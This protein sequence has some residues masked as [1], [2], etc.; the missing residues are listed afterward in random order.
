MIGA[1]GGIRYEVGAGSGIVNCS[2][3]LEPLIGV[4][5]VQ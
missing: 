2:A 3:V 4:V 1:S 5:G